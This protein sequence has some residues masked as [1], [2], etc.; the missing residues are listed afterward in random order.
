MWFGILLFAMMVVGFAASKIVPGQK[1]PFIQE[2]PPMRLPQ[3][4][5][6]AV[7]TFARLKWYLKEAVPLFILGT[8]ALFVSDKLNILK[9]IEDILSPL[10][11]SLLGLPVK[12]TEAFIIGFLR[13]DYGAA[14]LYV[15]SRTGQLDKVQIM[16]SLLVITLFVPCI[17]QFFVTVKERGVKIALLIAGFVFAFA[18]LFGGGLNFLL[19]YLLARGIAVI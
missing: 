18:F 1:S 17:A 10:V 13:R 15:L 6:I 19:R 14:G 2:I 12:A 16:V 5:N 4:K 9:W 3:I 11:V 8:V 7:K